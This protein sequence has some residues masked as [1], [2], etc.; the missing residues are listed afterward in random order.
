[1]LVPSFKDRKTAIRI[2]SLT[3]LNQKKTHKRFIW[4]IIKNKKDIV[5]NDTSLP[6]NFY[7]YGV[8][9][10]NALSPNT[11]SLPLAGDASTLLQIN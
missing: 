5:D 10:I 8:L 1:M 3:Y 4:L 9:G 6:I 7:Y 11:L 2:K